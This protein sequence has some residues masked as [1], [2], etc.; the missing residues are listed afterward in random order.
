MTSEEFCAIKQVDPS[1]VT[2]DNYQLF[3]DHLG[4]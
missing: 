2:D 1:A 3:V 4:L